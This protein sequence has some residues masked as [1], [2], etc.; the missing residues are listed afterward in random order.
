MRTHFATG[1]AVIGRPEVAACRPGGKRLTSNV[2]AV[3]CLNCKNK[4]AY[5]VAKKVADDARETKFQ[6]QE[7]REYGEPWHDGVITCKNGHTLLRYRGRSCYGHY[8]DWECSQCD[9][10]PSRLT[11]TGMSF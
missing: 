5:Q 2:Y 7:P 4:A 1:P 6:A 11:E 8:D 9:D 3:D 10:K